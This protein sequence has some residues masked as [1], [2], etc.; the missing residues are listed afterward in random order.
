MR[1]EGKIIPRNLTARAAYQVPGNPTT[2]RPEDAVA[3]CFPG[4]EIDVRNLDRRFF[5]G[6]VFDFVY[7]DSSENGARLSYLDPLLDPDLQREA[8]WARTLF[9]QLTD[10]YKA[11]LEADTWYLQWIELQGHRIG[12]VRPDGTPLHGLLVWR[13]VRSLDPGDTPLRIGLRRRGGEAGEI[14]LEGRR[15][16]YSDPRSGTIS[17]AFEPGELTQSLCSPWQHDFQECLCHY[18]ASNHPDIVYGEVPIGEA[19]LPGGLPRDPE[20]AN[21][22]IDWLRASRSP[23][24]AAA[25]LATTPAN[26][27]YRMDHHEINRAWQTLNVVLEGREIADRYVP[28]TFERAEPFERPEQLVERIVQ[29]LAPL[30]MALTVEYLYARFSLLS[31]DQAASRGG[32]ALAEDV[33]FVRQ[34]LMLIA[35]SEMQHLH[36]ANQLLWQIEESGIIPGFKYRPVLDQAKDVPKGDGTMRAHQLRRLDQDTLDDFIGAEHPSGGIDGAYARVIATLRGDRRYAPHMVELAERIASDG[37]R[38]ESRFMNI[39]ERLRSYA[40]DAAPFPYLRELRIGTEAEARPACDKFREIIE[41]L[42]MAYGAFDS[43]IDDEVQRAR[44]AM[45]E[46]LT[47]GEELAERGVGIPFYPWPQC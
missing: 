14:E 26:R 40:G 41:N 46:L 27:P 13:I 37:M 4:L 43:H 2:S 25:A 11:P 1:R 31:P 19:T 8:G 24:M 39:Q 29:V 28:P 36:W 21:T 7:G 44:A 16:Q 47:I 45:T 30:E 35:V 33:T 20:R 34:E 18:W 17:R 15:R 6:L 42:Q 10:T 23:G 5:P 38:H 9:Q 3:N 12:L 22:R 32:P